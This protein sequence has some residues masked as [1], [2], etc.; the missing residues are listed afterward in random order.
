MEWNPK[1][2]NTLPKLKQMEIFQNH[3]LDPY[4]LSLSKQAVASVGYLLPYT[5]THFKRRKL[6]LH[7]TANKNTIDLC[8]TQ[9]R[10]LEKY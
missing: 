4:Y 3:S 6:S 9:E 7:V 1:V 2:N 5:V 10:I 8:I